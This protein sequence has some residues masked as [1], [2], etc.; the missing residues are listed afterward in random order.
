VPGNCAAKGD[1]IR[2]GGV[3]QAGRRQG[4]RPSASTSSGPQAN[5][6]RRKDRSSGRV[7][8]VRR[9]SRHTTNAWCWGKRRR[10]LVA[11][12][13]TGPAWRVQSWAERF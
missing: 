9:T 8:F 3:R 11:W 6:L 13:G 12:V 5:R 10:T 2:H 4:S 1:A 7:A